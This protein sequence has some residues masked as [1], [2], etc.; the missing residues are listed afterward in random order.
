MDFKIHKAAKSCLAVV[1]QGTGRGPYGSSCL[2]QPPI[3]GRS[4]TDTHKQQLLPALQPGAQ[5]D[6]P[7][8]HTLQQSFYWCREDG[9]G[10][11]GLLSLIHNE[12][13]A[14]PQLPGTPASSIS[15]TAVVYSKMLPWLLVKIRFWTRPQPKIKI[16]SRKWRRCAPT[17]PHT[18]HVLHCV[19]VNVGHSMTAGPAWSRSCRSSAV[20]LGAEIHCCGQPDSPC[21]AQDQLL[22]RVC[23]YTGAKHRHVTTHWVSFI[24]IFHRYFKAEQYF[25]KANSTTAAFCFGASVVFAEAA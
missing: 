17:H 13:A 1:V 24:Q 18:Q 25:L 5:A 2:E 9:R 12:S 23:S 6:T 22:P 11:G 20:L 10:P 7:S 4:G 8:P 16:F 19:A 3:T 21:L 14:A 15:L